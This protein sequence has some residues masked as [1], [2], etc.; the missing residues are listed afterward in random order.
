MV[1]YLGGDG[2][3]TPPHSMKIVVHSPLPNSPGGRPPTFPLCSSAS[4][5]SLP[6]ACHPSDRIRSIALVSCKT[7]PVNASV[8]PGSTPLCAAWAHRHTRP[9]CAQDGHAHPR[10]VTTT[11]AAPLVSGP[12]AP[13]SEL[14]PWRDSTHARARARAP[15]PPRARCLLQRLEPR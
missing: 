3:H 10:R 5:T 6:C 2:G 1:S 13:Q 8:T 14:P 11:S 7:R 15:G 4:L 9:S 12:P